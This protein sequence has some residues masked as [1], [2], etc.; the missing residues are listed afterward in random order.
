M[1]FITTA[2]ATTIGSTGLTVGGAVS[3]V[4]TGISVYSGLAAANEQKRT[5]DFNRVIA[6]RN[7]V[8]QKNAADMNYKL[9]MAQTG[10]AMDQA[11]YQAQMQQWDTKMQQN[12]MTQQMDA[13]LRNANVAGGESR[14]DA[15]RQRAEMMRRMAVTNNKF[16]KAGVVGG[17]GTPLEVLSDTA[18]KLELAVQDAHYQGDAK[19]QSSMLSRS[20]KGFERKLIGI[21][22]SMAS[23]YT[24][25]AG[26][27][28]SAIDQ[29]AATSSRM[30]AK[31]GADLSWWSVKNAPSQ[32]PAMRTAAIAGGISGAASTYGSSYRSSQST[33]GSSYGSVNNLMGSISKY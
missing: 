25:A 16:A 21:Q 20:A 15:R 17:V 13:D 7:M 8:A 6:E 27:A 33:P 10:A 5:E 2:L 28:Q 14:E 3:L 4:G 29:F 26:R 1:A 18:E 22:G 23:E 31:R 11:A 9:Q 12:L 24:L 19:R 32:A 30:N